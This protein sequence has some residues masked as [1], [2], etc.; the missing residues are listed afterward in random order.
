MKDC[1]YDLILKNENLELLVYNEEVVRREIAEIRLNECKINRRLDM[2]QREKK[3]L[4]ELLTWLKS[5]NDYVSRVERLVNQRTHR[6]GIMSIKRQVHFGQ[7]FKIP[8]VQRAPRNVRI[9]P[10]GFLPQ[11]RKLGNYVCADSERVYGSSINNGG[12][13]DNFSVKHQEK[14]WLKRSRYLDREVMAQE[15]KQTSLSS[16]SMWIQTISKPVRKR[17]YK[18]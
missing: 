4:V 5:S 17:K 8:L 1:T 11:E 9:L 12:R 16:V 13:S 3:D 14:G 15:I 6:Q 7:D 18:L 10:R 2:V